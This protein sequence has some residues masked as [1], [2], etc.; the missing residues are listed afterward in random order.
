MQ[1][2]TTTT[3]GAASARATRVVDAR[4]LAARLGTPDELLLL[5]PREE[6]TF[7]RGHLLLAANLPLSRLELQLRR[8]VPRRDVPIVLVGDDDAAAHRAAKVLAQAGYADVAR[9]DGGDAAWV[10]AGQAVFSGVHV[11]SKAFGEAV[12]HANGTPRIAADAVLRERRDGAP[13]CYVDSRPMTEYREFSLPGAAGCPGA[14]LL[15]RA[16]AR[17][18]GRPIVVNCAGR[19]RSII[20]A[21][22]LINAGVPNPVFALENGTMGWFLIGEPLAHG[23]TDLLPLPDGAQLAIA[24]ERAERLA[25]RLGVRWIDAAELDAMLADAT[26]T[27]YRLD[28]RLPEDYAGGHLPGFANAPGGQLVQSTDLYAPVRHARIVLFDTLGVQAPMTAHWLVQMGWDVAVLRR[29]A[30]GALSQAGPEPCELAF[31]PAGTA[32]ITVD[33]LAARRAGVTVVDVDDSRRYRHGHLPGAAWLPRSRIEGVLR[34]RPGTH[35]FVAD[36]LALARFAAADAARAGL[37]AAWL[38]ARHRDACERL[39]TSTD[40]RLLAE[41]D[42][43]WASPYHADDVAQAMRDYLAWETGLLSRIDREPGVRFRVHVASTETTR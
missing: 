18:D 25:R 16:P 33:A 31:E 43:A 36:D 40:A 26:R 2:R 3:T 12:E 29:D 6:G 14:E 5:D 1:A 15:L 27:T 4:G 23:E 9:L 28:V 19:T 42:D 41:P 13:R 37:D 17:A 10:A 39:G 34:G 24:R 7:A 38:D 21:Q 20:G 32:S 35:V 8:R 22:S 30:A 11:P